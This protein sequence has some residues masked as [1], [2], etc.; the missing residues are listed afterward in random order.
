LNGTIIVIVFVDIY[1]DE[2]GSHD[3]LL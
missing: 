1:L 3:S 2:Y